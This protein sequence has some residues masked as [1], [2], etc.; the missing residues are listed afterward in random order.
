M[1][2]TQSTKRYPRTI[3]AAVCI[4]W[5]ERNRLI[6][7]KL[8][9]EIRDLIK[10]GI[11]HLYLFGTAGEGYAVTDDQYLQV[12]RIFAEEMSGPELHPMVG[13]INN[14]LPVMLKRM[15]Q[16]Y[17]LGIR[18]F[19]FSLPA[20]GALNDRELFSFFHAVCDPYPDCR[21]MHYNLMRA[22]RVITPEEYDR[23]A[24]EIPNFVG[25]KFTTLEM[26]TVH[27]LVQFPSP[28]QFFLGEIGFGYGSLIGECGLLI[29]IANS[30]ISRAWAFFE[31]AVKREATTVL[32]YQRQLASML[33][34]LLSIAGGENIDGAYD[35]LFCR[36]LDSDFPLKLLPPYEGFEEKIFEQYKQYLIHE[37]PDWLENKNT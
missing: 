17:S 32:V 2:S 18:D 24:K 19:Q 26:M 36:L 37:M 16:A 21:F 4:P 29:S 10:R 11:C 3:L 6:E 33:S 28:L 31:A 1:I 13:Q 23:L 15:E 34:T 20:W 9:Q 12:V 27:K 14:S 35:K 25:A 30:N 22:K 7:D 5:D 8:R